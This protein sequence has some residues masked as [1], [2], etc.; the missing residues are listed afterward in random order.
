MMVST[1]PPESNTVGEFVMPGSAYDM[2]FLSEPF[3]LDIKPVEKPVVKPD[4][5]VK[6]INGQTYEF[7]IYKLLDQYDHFLKL[8]IETPFD[9][10]TET[11]KLLA[12]HVA[13][14]MIETMKEHRGIGLAANQ[15]G[16]G[17]RLFVMGA[18]GVGYAFFN[19]E[20][21]EVTGE[22]IFKE[23]CLSFPGLFLPVKRPATVKL[24][25]QDMNGEIKEQE[26]SGLSA[27]IILHEYDH[28]L[29]IVFTQQVS[30]I[31]VD[32]ERTKVKKNLKVLKQQQ[33]IE[34]KQG[35]IRKAFEKVAQ[36]SKQ[37]TMSDQ[38]SGKD[39]V[40]SLIIKT[41]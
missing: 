35:L 16:L 33:F 4:L 34:E 1:N 40:K 5:K 19:P 30:K 36:E 14:S 3:Q 27:R 13:I 39:E 21:L 12:R 10:N 26:F 37:K 22:E 9:F 20:I 31:V 23:G 15:V 8:P 7:E 24:R 2:S 11:N 25:Y 6:Y 32:R 18:E 41:E 29:G 38:A 28:L 17:Y